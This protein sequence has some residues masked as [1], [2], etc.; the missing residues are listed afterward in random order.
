MQFHVSNLNNTLFN[1]MHM[2]NHNNI[3]N[4]YFVLDHMK[5]IVIGFYM[6]ITK[7]SKQHDC[8]SF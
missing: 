6:D 2:L 1:N 7:H 8:C 4:C 3:R 5:T